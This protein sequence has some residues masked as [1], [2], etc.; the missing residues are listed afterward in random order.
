[1]TY[2]SQKSLW[3]VLQQKEDWSL[4][5][6]V[7]LFAIS[8]SYQVYNFSI[9]KSNGAL[10]PKT[11]QAFQ[12]V[13]QLGGRGVWILPPYVTFPNCRPMTTVHVPWDWFVF[14]IEAY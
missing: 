1:M 13:V 9:K 14:R 6:H 2:D 7:V 10:L 12:N 8:K 11:G 3:V 5:L 4:V